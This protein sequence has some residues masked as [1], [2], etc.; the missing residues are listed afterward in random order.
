[1]LRPFK[2]R[3]NGRKTCP[4]FEHTVQDYLQVFADNSVHLGLLEDIM[5]IGA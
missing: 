2:F 3:K 5:Q 1:M 4:A